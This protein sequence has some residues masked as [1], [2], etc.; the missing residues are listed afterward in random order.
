MN[1]LRG[2]LAALICA[3]WVTTAF[4]QTTGTAPDYSAWRALSQKVNLAIDSGRTSTRVL[5]DLRAEV[6]A[7]RQQFLDASE[8]NGSRITTLQSQLEALGEAPAE[9]DTEDPDIAARRA[10]LTAQLATLTAPIRAAEE[11]YTAADGLV[12]EIDTLAR[13]RQ[14]ERL[15]ELGPSPVNPALWTP[16]V[17]EGSRAFADIGG[18]IA[19]AIVDEDKRAELKANMPLVLL[20]TAVGILLLARGRRWAER[21]GL[22]LRGWGGRGRGVWGLLVSLGRI[23][24]PLLGLLALTRALFATQMVGPQSSLLLETV[25][26]W[27]A[28]LLGYRW[29]CERVFSKVDEDAL[30]PMEP[31]I[32]AAARRYGTLIGVFVV[33]A[34]IVSVISEGAGLADSVSVVLAFPLVVL[35]A[36]LLF[37]LGQILRNHVADQDAE[38]GEPKSFLL[39]T[40]GFIGLAT[41]LISIVAPVMVGVGYEHAGSAL[42]YPTVLTLGLFGLILVLQRFSADIYVFVTRQDTQAREALIPVLI[43][44]VLVLLAAPLLALIWGARVSELTEIWARFREGFAVGDTRISPTDFLTFAIIFA[45]GYMLTRLVQ[46]ALRTSVLPKTKID[47]GGRNAIT[48][49]VGYV[50]IFLAALAAITGAGIDLSSLA[51][52]AGALSVGIGFGLQNIVS[53]FVSGII[54]LIER[55]IAEGDWIEVGGQMGYV[56]DI[57]VRSTRI[58]TF[59]RSDVIVPNA[60][61]VSGT[62]TNYTR[63]NT[64]GRVIVPVGVAYGTDTRKVETIL[65]E[66]ANAHPMVLSHPAPNVVMQGFGA[67]SMDFEIRAILRDVNWVLSTKSDMNHEIAKRFAEEGIEIP[68][69]QRDLWLRNPEMLKGGT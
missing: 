62:V 34:S 39:R 66:I 27:G 52:V 26:V 57:S 33:L 20:L 58:E 47:Q 67:D 31:S 43:G 23:I 51:I 30:L 6:A 14:T 61:L 24:L 10:E 2:W 1:V 4:A 16:A 13:E 11:A 49:G 41:M 7:F 9:G 60:D 15:L 46:G 35:T 28:I 38:E 21:M 3:L 63:G 25:P 56:R 68:F 19:K 54:L 45:F 29:L 36:L 53:N 17:V 55:P 69:A 22:Y 44:F 8:Q 5:D 40:V 32:R 37:R 12:R 42:L 64:V 18:E 59:D 50:G 48:S 65:R